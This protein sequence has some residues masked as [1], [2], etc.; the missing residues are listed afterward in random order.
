MDGQV[1][2]FENQGLNLDQIYNSLTVNKDKRMTFFIHT[3]L[4]HNKQFK[5]VT[6]TTVI[7]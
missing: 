2:V 1:W 4:C 3:L 6:E 5:A 7:H